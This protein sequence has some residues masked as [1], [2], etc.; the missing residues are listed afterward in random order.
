MRNVFTNA[1]LKGQLTIG[2]FIQEE[3]TPDSSQD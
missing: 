2:S 1:E 3:V